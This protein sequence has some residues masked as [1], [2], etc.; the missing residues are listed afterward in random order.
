MEQLKKYKIIRKKLVKA[1]S[2]LENSLEQ[3]LNE[4]IQDSVIQ[5]FE[6]TFELL[7]KTL[8]IYLLIQGF[9]E[10]TPR[11]VLKKSF[12]ISLI[13]DIDLFIDM[14][15]I[16]NLTSHTYNEELAEDVYEFIKKNHKEIWKVIEKLVSDDID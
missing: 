2:R 12:E 14:I 4:Y 1:F 9:D 10:K 11:W 3:E 6:F 16:R 15:D 7:W 5:R 8:K 13:E